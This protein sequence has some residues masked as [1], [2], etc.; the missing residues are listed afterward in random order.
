VITLGVSNLPRSI[1]FYRDGL[2]FP[3]DAK[4]DADIAF[5]RTSGARLALGITALVLG[6]PC[7]LI[8]GTLPVATKFAQC[9][10]DTRRA[11]TAFFYGINV[12]SA[13]TGAALGT[14]LLLPALGGPRGR[15]SRPANRA[16]PQTLRRAARALR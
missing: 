1:R 5:F 10:E 12:G 3:T 6:G 7:F 16:R 4:D 2:G 14:F 9:D 13:L 8:G 15:R 11:D